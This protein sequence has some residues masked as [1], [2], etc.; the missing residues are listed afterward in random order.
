VVP[1]ALATATHVAVPPEFA[2]MPTGVPLVFASG[3]APW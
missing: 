1:S 2:A 3:L